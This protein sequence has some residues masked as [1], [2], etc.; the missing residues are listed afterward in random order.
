MTSIIQQSEM[1]KDVSDDRIGQEMQQPTGQFPLYLVSSEAKRR[2]DLRQRF[3][4]EQAGPPPTTTVQDDLL[5]SIMNSQAQGQGIAQGINP[6]QQQPQQ[7]QPGAVMPQQAPQQMAQMQPPSQAPNAGIMQQGF[8]QG[9]AIQR[10]ANKGTVHSEAVGDDE[11]YPSNDVRMMPRVKAVGRAVKKAVKPAVDYVGRHIVTQPEEKYGR[12][13]GEMGGKDIGN[14]LSLATDNAPRFDDH[15]PMPLEAGVEPV[16]VYSPDLT[17]PPAKAS[18]EQLAA[19]ILEGRQNTL[20]GEIDT[21]LSNYPVGGRTN[22]GYLPLGAKT[23]TMDK[24]AMSANLKDI[25]RTLPT[26]QPVPGS[27]TW[28]GGDLDIAG[29]PKGERDRLYNTKLAELNEGPDPYA[30]IAGRLDKRDADIEGA[31]DS[32]ISDAMMRAGL[33]IM[34]GKSQYAAVNIGTG[35][36]EGVDAYVAGKKDINARKERATDA[37]TALIGVQEQR[38]SALKSEAYRHANGEIT[39]RQYAD[40]IK[41]IEYDAK[42][43]KHQILS[44]EKERERANV[45]RSNELGVA[46]KKWKVEGDTQAALAD[47]EAARFLH[48]KVQGR[49]DRDADDRLKRYGLKTEAD[50]YAAGEAK[51]KAGIELKDAYRRQDRLEKRGERAFTAEQ[52]QKDRDTQIFLQQSRD[53]APTPAMKNARAAMEDPAL[54]KM[55]KEQGVGAKAAMA[56]TTKIGQSWHRVLKSWQGDAGMGVMPKGKEWDTMKQNFITDLAGEMSITPAAAAVYAEIVV[57]RS[58]AAAAVGSAGSGLAAQWE[59]GSDGVT[60]RKQ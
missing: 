25:D 41:K 28:Q 18:P 56:A 32:N 52:K 22:N 9:G 5:R 10:Y 60:R 1:L 40:T 38:K 20:Q 59:I 15:M 47:A 45:I 42:V 23:L 13:R 31:A 29:I 21:K 14:T 12:Y 55:M 57:A 43:Q 36:K 33:G 50:R 48:D 27:L 49:E 44:A 30:A 16:E 26:G 35:G 6:Q 11:Y 24:A 51:D 37:R 7:Q 34:G 17:I 46:N 53:N 4:A 19:G 54:G 2:A 58:K 3:K 39:D 8:A